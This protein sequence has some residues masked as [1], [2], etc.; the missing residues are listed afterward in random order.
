MTHMPKDILREFL[1][2]IHKSKMTGAL[3][4]H[5]SQGSPSGTIQWKGKRC[6]NPQFTSVLGNGSIDNHRETECY[7]R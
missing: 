7:R 1:D 2:H 6:E 5:F 3:T 4:I